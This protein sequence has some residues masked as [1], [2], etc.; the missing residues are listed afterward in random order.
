M[1]HQ[2]KTA[3]VGRIDLDGVQGFKFAENECLRIGR[4]AGTQIVGGE[5]VAL[6]LGSA[7]LEHHI[8]HEYPRAV[9]VG[10][11][12]RRA[13]AGI[14]GVGEPSQVRVNRDGLAGEVGARIGSCAREADADGVSGGVQE[15]KGR[16]RREG[17]GGE[18]RVRHNRPSGAV[19][20]C[21]RHINAR[22]FGETVGVRGAVDVDENLVADRC[23]GR[24]F[25]R[26]PLHDIVPGH[27]V[28]LASTRALRG[29]VETEQLVARVGECG[30]GH[31]RHVVVHI[32]LGADFRGVADCGHPPRG[33]AI[34]VAPTFAIT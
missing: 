23:D 22:D 1:A 4:E 8:G 33:T 16:H 9:N 31:A 2:P 34:E 14:E 26:A 28:G 3:G 18:L 29:E 5:V 32:P 19:G 24:R 15:R 17:V 21:R 7:I 13:P 12:A 10:L 27:V 6:H 25:P 30:V 20:G 11:T